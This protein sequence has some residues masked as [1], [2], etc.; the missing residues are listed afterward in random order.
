MVPA[1]SLIIDRFLT[2]H[3]FLLCSPSHA[4]LTCAKTYAKINVSKPLAFH[5]RVLGH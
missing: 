4:E 1:S 3:L 2:H 5:D